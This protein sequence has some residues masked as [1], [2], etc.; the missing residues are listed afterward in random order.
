[1]QLNGKSF[2]ERVHDYKRKNKG[3]IVKPE[4][5]R[6]GELIPGLVAEYIER[7]ALIGETRNKEV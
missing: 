4:F 6:I 7:C 1:M 5:I 2:E 3:R